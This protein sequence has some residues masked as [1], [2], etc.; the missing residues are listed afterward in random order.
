MTRPT[1]S[2]PVRPP[3]AAADK[4]RAAA[5]KPVPC[6]CGSTAY[7]IVDVGDGLPRTDC[8]HAY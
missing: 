4:R 5:P 7:E 3:D 1:L 8:C 2:K 6:L